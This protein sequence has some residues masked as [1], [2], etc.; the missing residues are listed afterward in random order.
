[1]RIFVG[2]SCKKHNIHVF[3]PEGYNR[4]VSSSAG[5]NQI[6]AAR[7]LFKFIKNH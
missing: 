3:F 1:M 5:I 4:V 7:E 2:E 6:R